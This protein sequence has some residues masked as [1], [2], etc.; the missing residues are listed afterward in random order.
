MTT[1]TPKDFTH[2]LGMKGFSDIMLTNHFTLYEGYVKNS[3]LLMTRL[4]GDIE[5]GSVEYYELKRRLAWE[6]DGMRMHELYFKNLSKDKKEIGKETKNLLEKNF[7]TLENWQKS[8]N[9]N[10]LIRGIGWVM[11]LQDNQTKEV[12]H[13]WIGEHNQGHILDCKVLLVMDMWEH[14][15]MTDY[16]IK[17]AEYIE[18]FWNNIDWNVVENRL[19]N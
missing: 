1:Y 16:G 13:T 3:N 5:S 2:L 4:D 19:S 9:T 7:S 8:F 17:K 18:A 11:L 12:F 6:I 14:A 15:Y 10:C